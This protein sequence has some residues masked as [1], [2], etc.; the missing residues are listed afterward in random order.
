MRYRIGQFLAFLGFILLLFFAITLQTETPYYWVCGAGLFITLF[1]TFLIIQY[2]P[3]PPQSTRFSRYKK[4][5]KKSS[6]ETPPK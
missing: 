5:G 4:T 2:R 3:P 6:S 1:G